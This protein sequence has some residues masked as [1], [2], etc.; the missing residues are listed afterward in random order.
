MKTNVQCTNYSHISPTAVLFGLRLIRMVIWIV[1][2][3]F[4]K[5][6]FALSRIPL[7]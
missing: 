6:L 2:L 3:C 7:T 1:Y 5:L 4:E